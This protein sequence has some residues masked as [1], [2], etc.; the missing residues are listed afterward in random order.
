MWYNSYKDC[1]PD[2][3]LFKNQ[4]EPNKGIIGCEM[5]ERNGWG[6]KQHIP[7]HKAK[8]NLATLWSFLFGTNVN[9]KEK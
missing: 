3:P 1:P 9:V 8:G 5:H 7:S 2:E 6:E 4:V